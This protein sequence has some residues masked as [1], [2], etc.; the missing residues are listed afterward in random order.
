MKQEE[1]QIELATLS[2]PASIQVPGEARGLVIFAH[3]SGSSRSSPRNQF[4]AEIL[5]RHGMATLLADLLTAFEDEQYKNRFNIALLSN[6]LVKITEWALG[7]PDLQYLPAGYF[8]ASTGA[9]AALQAAALL[10][11][12]IK[13]VVSRGGRP[14]LA[15]HALAQVKAP[16]LLIVGSLDTPVIGLNQLSYKELRC[17]KKL[18]VVEGASH[19]FEEPGTLEKAAQ[20]AAGWFEQHLFLS[21][22]Q[23]QL[24]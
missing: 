1:V 10:D 14:D 24:T 16:T 15:G 2:L 12:N 9:A 11:N 6:R 17:R 19:L 7:R 21:Q 13:A 22:T 20:L 8:G 3:G 18:E 23:H 5:N 4:V